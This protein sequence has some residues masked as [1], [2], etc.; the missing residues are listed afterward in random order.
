MEKKKTTAKKPAAKKEAVKVV[1]N[2]EVIVKNQPDYTTVLN[3]ILYALIIISIL[4]ALNLC[5]NLI[6][7]TNNNKKSESTITE[8]ENTE[9][10]VS[11]FEE[12]TTSELA[13]KVKAGGTQVVYIGRSTCGYCVKFIPTLKQAQKDLGYKTIYVDLTKVTSSDAETLYAYDSFVEENFGYTPM[14]LVF[15]DGNFV[16]GTVG[17]TEVDEFKSFLKEAGIN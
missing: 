16:K 6:T 17:Y 3:R 12:L 11:E 15:K 10:D 2:N 1:K 8:E 4:L 9:Y 13:E 5:V 7:G 14:V